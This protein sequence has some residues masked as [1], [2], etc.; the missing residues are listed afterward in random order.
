MGIPLCSERP[1]PVKSRPCV[2]MNQQL[3]GSP[4]SPTAP[5]LPPASQPPTGSL[6]WGNPPG[7]LRR[8]WEILGWAM[9]SVLGPQQLLWEAAGGGSGPWQGWIHQ[10]G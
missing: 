6:D 4:R 7:S 8:G 5:V 3:W 2:S 1:S 9:R 10:G